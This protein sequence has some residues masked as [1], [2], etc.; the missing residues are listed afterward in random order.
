MIYGWYP[1]WVLDNLSVEEIGMYYHEGM[2]ADLY[3]HQFNIDRSKDIT[4][5]EREAL[6]EMYYTPEE[7]KNLEEF[8][9]G[10]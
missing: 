7:L 4:Q 1:D 8:K 5:E 6:H 3:R 2:K 9:K 10:K